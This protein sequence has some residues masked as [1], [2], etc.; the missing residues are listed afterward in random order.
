MQV[1]RPKLHMCAQLSW[2]T[3]VKFTLL[4]IMQAHKNKSQG[5]PPPSL[6]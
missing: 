1:A 4:H 3:I 5:R 6:A 2:G